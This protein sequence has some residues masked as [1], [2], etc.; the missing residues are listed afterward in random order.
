MYG[1]ARVQRLEPIERGECI[2]RCCPR[3]GGNDLP[4]Y[5]RMKRFR[6]GVDPAFRGEVALGDPWT[7]VKEPRGFVERLHIDLYD[8]RI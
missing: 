6:R 1:R 8:A 7:F 2:G 4:R 3:A 5:P